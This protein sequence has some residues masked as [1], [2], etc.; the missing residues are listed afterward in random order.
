MNTTTL[1]IDAIIEGALLAAGEPLSIKALQNV[2]GEEDCPTPEVIHEAL[3]RLGDACHERAVELVEVANGFHYRVRAHLAPWISRLWEEKPPRYSRA[4]LETLAIVAYRQPVTR[5]E[6]EDIRGVGVSSS[7]MK[8]LLE[9]EWVKVVGHRELPGRPAIYATTKQFL[10][11]FALKSLSELPTLADI[12]DID[13][14]SEELGATVEA[15]MSAVD[16]I[17]IVNATENPHEEE[18]IA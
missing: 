13:K 4:L 15:S 11:H 12:R 14:I 5:A 9:H 3:A 16:N 6:I 7:V 8:T 18:Q 17:V 1:P 2:F 10:D